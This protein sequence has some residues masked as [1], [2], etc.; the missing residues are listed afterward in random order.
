MKASLKTVIAIVSAA[1]FCVA[2]AQKSFAANTNV[3]V[4]LGGDFFSPSVVNISVNDSVTW[5]WTNSFHSTTSGTN[6]NPGEDNGV[7][8]GLWDSG[9]I[10]SL[11][12]SFTNT[13]TTNGSF[14][15]YCSVH[16]PVGM[17][18]LVLVAN[19][20]LPPSLA[21]TNP[22]NGAVFAAPAN[23]TIQAAVTNGSTS[24]TNV[25]FL[26][27]TTVLANETSGP[28][29]AIANSLA[30]GS[31]TLSAIAQ[32]DG[33]LS[34][35]NSVGISVVNPI[36]VMLTDGS[37]PSGTDFQFSYSADVGLNY[38]VQRSEDLFNWIPLVTNTAASNPVVFDD[39]N[40]TNSLDFYRVGRL[41]NP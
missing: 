9:V 25:Q 20:T 39:S 4:G 2:F 10:F 34:A 3:I 36:A 29:S 31:H 6:G 17:T 12:H 23:V 35:T 14:S 41:P 40:A 37:R 1:F 24:V 26:V 16:Y 21:I 18:G 19:S 38:V 22:L 8:S 28:F 30:A 5:I 15:Y 13:F 32:D 11:P 27:D 33:G 7:P